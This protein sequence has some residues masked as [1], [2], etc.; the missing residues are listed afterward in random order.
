MACLKT[1]LQLLFDFGLESDFMF[2]YWSCLVFLFLFCSLFL[3]CSNLGLEE[4]ER[5]DLS[6]KMEKE[7]LKMVVCRHR[8]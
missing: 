6:E 7:D 1:N 2:R 4:E 3:S 5:C 8:L